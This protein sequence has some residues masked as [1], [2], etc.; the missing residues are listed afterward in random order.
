[1]SIAHL[2][3]PA[4]SG[5]DPEIWFD[6]SRQKLAIELCS[7]CPALLACLRAADAV[8]QD[9]TYVFGVRGGLTATRRAATRRQRMALAS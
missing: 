4:C 8:E 6:K 5:L 7:A 3:E 1:M 9:E 2:D